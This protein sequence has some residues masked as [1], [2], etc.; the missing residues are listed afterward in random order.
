MAFVV[1]RDKVGPV[2][3]AQVNARVAHNILQGK[4]SEIIR[5]FI[6]S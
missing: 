2:G 1:L 3:E 6:P 5:L 4:M